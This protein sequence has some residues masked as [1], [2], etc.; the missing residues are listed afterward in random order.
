MTARMKRASVVSPIRRETA[1]AM[2]R[3]KM[4]GLLNWRRKTLK[5]DGGALSG[6]AFFPYW[7]RRRAASLWERP[8]GDDPAFRSAPDSGRACQRGPSFGTSAVRDTSPAPL[9]TGRYIL[10]AGVLA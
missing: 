6:R 4:R 3:M 9:S 7:S 2:M 10:L 8:S 1:P 5:K